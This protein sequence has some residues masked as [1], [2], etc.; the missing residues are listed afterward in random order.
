MSSPFEVLTIVPTS[1]FSGILFRLTR[2]CEKVD[3]ELQETDRR[4]EYKNLTRTNWT[5]EFLVHLARTVSPLALCVRVGL[6][7]FCPPFSVFT[8]RR[9]N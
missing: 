8:S 1:C 7:S 2:S 6:S 9:T 4:E 3:F 5:R